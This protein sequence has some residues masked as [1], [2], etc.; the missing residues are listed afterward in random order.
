MKQAITLVLED[1]QIIELMQILID[2]DAEGAL[3]FLKTHF[4]G[5]VMIDV[6]GAGVRQV[7]G[8]LLKAGR[9]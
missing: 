9:E 4:K 5:K 8:N 7:S 3:A 1:A 2:D 6:P